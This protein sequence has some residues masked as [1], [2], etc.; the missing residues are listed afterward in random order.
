[1]KSLFLLSLIL[2]TGCD[3]KPE[4]AGAAAPASPVETKT[5]PQSPARPTTAAA[6][7]KVREI[8]QRGMVEMD[9]V[10]KEFDQNIAT[11]KDAAERKVRTDAKFKKLKEMKDA[12]TAEIQAA[13]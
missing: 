5:A 10:K 4:P 1:M 7:E 3:K 9:R 6:A 12:M 2:L 8:I 13:T 11:A